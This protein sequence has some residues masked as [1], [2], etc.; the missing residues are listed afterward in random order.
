MN[1]GGFLASVRDIR[2]PDPFEDKFWEK[3]KGSQL[4]QVFKRILV[5]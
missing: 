3:A 1:W 2:E 5:G 4:N